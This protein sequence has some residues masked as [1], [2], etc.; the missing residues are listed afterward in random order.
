MKI[1]EEHRQFTLLDDDNVEQGAVTFSL[2][3]DT[4]LIIDHT[5][6]EDAYTGKGYASK[7][8]KEV[9][10]KARRENKKIIPLCPYARSQFDR[11]PEYADVLKY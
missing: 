9:V 5:H 11:K 2:A 1:V 3:G 8:V 10:E 4:M 7:L 6:V